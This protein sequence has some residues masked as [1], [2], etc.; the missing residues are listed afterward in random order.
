VPGDRNPVFH[1]AISCKRASDTACGLLLFTG[2]NIAAQLDRVV[3]Y[4][5]AQ[6]VVMQRRLALQRVLDLPLQS[7]RVVDA[8]A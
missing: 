3:A 8:N 2:L 5:D 7:G 6:V 1:A 4:I